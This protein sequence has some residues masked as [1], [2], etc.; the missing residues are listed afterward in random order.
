M[1]KHIM[2]CS[3][4]GQYTMDDTC[5]ACKIR[6]VQPRP[7]KYSPED[8]YSEYRRR[9]KKEQLKDEGLL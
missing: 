5:K 8:K 4:C 3:T 1:A 6:T 7:P 9:A 2:K